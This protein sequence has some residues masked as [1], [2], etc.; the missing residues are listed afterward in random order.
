MRIRKSLVTFLPFYNSF[1]IHFVK[2]RVNLMILLI[3]KTVLFRKKI[4]G[5]RFSCTVFIST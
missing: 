3:S 5:N 2:M 4:V 1:C